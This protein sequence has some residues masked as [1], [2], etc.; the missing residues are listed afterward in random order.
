M[1]FNMKTV[2]FIHDYSPARAWLHL[3]LI[4]SQHMFS[5]ENAVIGTFSQWSNDVVNSHN[6]LWSD[7][8]VPELPSWHIEQQLVSINK[9]IN[10]G[11]NVILF[12]EPIRISQID[13]FQRIFNRYVDDNN[14]KYC[15]IIIISHPTVMLE[16]QCR[17][18]WPI[19]Y[20][21]YKTLLKNLKEFPYFI[22]E[23][24][25][26]LADADCHLLYNNIQSSAYM[27]DKRYYDEISN[28]LDIQLKPY[29]LP[30]R[31]PASYRSNFVRRIASILEVRHNSWPV[32]ADSSFFASLHCLDKNYP[33][34]MI[35][36]LSMRQELEKC[37][38]ARQIEKACNLREGSLVA[39]KPILEGKETDSSVPLPLAEFASLLS[40]DNRKRLAERFRKDYFLTGP[41][42]KRL[43]EEIES[44][45]G[46]FAA[47]AVKDQEPL[48]TV[49]TMTYNQEKYIAQC[50]D[51]VLAQRTKFPVRHLVLDHHSSDSTPKIVAEY[52][53]R[54]PS[55]QPVL[56][57]ARLEHEN[58]RG[59]CL[60]CKSK[61][62][63]FCDGDDYF[64]DPNKLQ[65]QVDYLEQH[66]ELSFCFHPVAAVFED[67]SPPRIFPGLKPISKRRNHIFE[68]ADLASGNFIQTNSVLYR[69]R[70]R[71]GL[72]DWFR[73]DIC[74]TDWYI[75]M[76]H[77]ETGNFGL[78]PRIMSAYRRHAGA[79]FA[80]CTQSTTAL[81]RKMAIPELV[82][83]RAC[84]NRMDK[85]Y[86]PKL[87][88]LG[89]QVMAD[90][91]EVA[92]LDKDNTVLD[93]SVTHFQ[94]FV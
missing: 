50:M 24:I 41:N 72:P 12:G 35:S 17:Q 39:S 2:Y 86:H 82:A 93:F 56:L 58:V 91:R 31:H 68:L 3:S 40:A 70:F 87:L 57:S 88:K 15:H 69:W 44:L 6:F 34:D 36:P 60:R 14:V 81:R 5:K 80:E 26:R 85:N 33:E 59:L 37:G 23:Y 90:L 63:I 30:W 75:H 49:L 78:I 11:N 25:K 27:P 7:N 83:I 89:R 55:I 79:M 10:E 66:P 29:S 52:A 77:A 43:L 42:Q 84:L 8:Y 62:A 38:L 18:Y 74:L 73:A 53:S 94:E 22:K 48:V 67:G 21:R 51:S 45:D 1:S 13:Y 92:R 46:N 28:L 19:S 71:G 9:I 65:I 61:Y 76:L 16:D 47:I 4:N 20:N 32:I 64:I 54:H